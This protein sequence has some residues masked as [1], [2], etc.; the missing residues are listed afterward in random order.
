MDH[1]MFRKFGHVTR[2]FKMAA[3]SKTF[4]SEAMRQRSCVRCLGAERMLSK[5][6][7]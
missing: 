4:E 1:N 6:S 2:V 5:K 7:S 3:K